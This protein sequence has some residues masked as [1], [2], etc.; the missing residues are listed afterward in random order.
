MKDAKEDFRLWDRVHGREVLKHLE[1]VSKWEPGKKDRERKERQ[2]ALEAKQ[3]SWLLKYL[4]KKYNLLQHN[5]TGFFRN[6][7]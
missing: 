6:L 4:A 7:L 2:L 5:Y 1:A 3:V